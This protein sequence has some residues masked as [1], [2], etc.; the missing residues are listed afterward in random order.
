MKDAGTTIVGRNI[1]I[2]NGSVTS[3]GALPSSREVD[4]KSTLVEKS[5]EYP[6]DAPPPKLVNSLDSNKI[7]QSKL[8]ISS[9]WSFYENAKAEMK[10]PLLFRALTSELGS[11]F[12]DTLTYITQIEEL[13]NSM[14]GSHG[15]KTEKLDALLN[16][17]NVK[18]MMS[19]LMTWAPLNVRD[20]IEHTLTCSGV[21]PN[22]YAWDEVL[23][24]SFF[25]NMYFGVLLSRMCDL[26]FN[27]PVLFFGNL[28]AHKKISEACEVLLSNCAHCLKTV[29]SYKL[30]TFLTHFEISNMSATDYEPMTS[31]SSSVGV[32]KLPRALL[33]TSPTQQSVNIFEIRWG[34]SFGNEMRMHVR[35]MSS[36]R[37][38]SGE[39]MSASEEDDNKDIFKMLTMTRSGESMFQ[40]L[41]LF[42]HIK[43]QH[44]SRTYNIMLEET[45]AVHL[46]YMN[47]M[48]IVCNEL[49][50]S[51]TKRNLYLGCVVYGELLYLS[52]LWYK[53]L[54]ACDEH[55][56]L[57]INVYDMLY[58]VGK[59]QEDIGKHVE[60]MAFREFERHFRL[61]TYFKAKNSQAPNVAGQGSV[62]TQM[63]WD[64]VLATVLGTIYEGLNVYAVNSRE[65]FER[66]KLFRVGSHFPI[67][68]AKTFV[69]LTERIM[70][71]LES[72]L[73][74]NKSPK[75]KGKTTRFRIDI[76]GVRLLLNEILSLKKSADQYVSEIG[77]DSTSVELL[78]IDFKR[79]YYIFHLYLEPKSLKANSIASASPVAN[80]ASAAMNDHEIW[81]SHRKS[82][83][84]G[85]F[86]NAKENTVLN[87]II[88]DVETLK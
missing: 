25:L 14:E 86:E 36:P 19:K 39:I 44:A 8:C 22:E 53:F 58:A 12:A 43:A 24:S 23:R 30:R 46:N 5:Q 57:S 61:Q 45:F 84:N 88:K 67:Y 52:Q 73:S 78:K 62:N 32:A 81:S 63:S 31:F 79:W 55:K 38:I 85:E 29:D 65:C 71:S 74:S 37:I 9:I 7:D 27:H 87:G 51:N 41:L 6:R 82:D 70:K 64:K 4:L 28:V 66:A 26:S 50:N 68:L 15:L 40:V 76:N 72:Y 34:M 17:S 2:T 35:E 3:N 56:L 80:I 10:A 13:A 21:S 60:G 83:G 69:Y 59:L 20:F 47:Q 33:D 16:E 75:Y 49:L 42:Y 18:Q 11:A 54:R 77:K 1:T 48:R